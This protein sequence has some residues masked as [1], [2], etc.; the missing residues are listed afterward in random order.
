[1]S[2]RSER[3]GMSRGSN[4]LSRSLATEV[5][6]DAVMEAGNP[7]RTSMFTDVNAME[8]QRASEVTKIGVQRVTDVTVAVIWSVKEGIEVTEVTRVSLGGHRC[9]CCQ[10]PALYGGDEPQMWS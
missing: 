4:R 6:V 10:S 9:D 5:M 7:T 8:V 1:M 2:L 3:S